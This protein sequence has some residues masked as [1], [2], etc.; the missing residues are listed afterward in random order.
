[1]REEVKGA[2]RCISG[3]TLLILASFAV[4]SLL[5]YNTQVGPL[6]QG[7]NAKVSL[8]KQKLE[9]VEKKIEVPEPLAI[10]APPVEAGEGTETPTLE[11]LLNP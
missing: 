11:S 6:L 1:M 2:T 7:A 9:S 4:V 5:L 8:S 10:V 3:W